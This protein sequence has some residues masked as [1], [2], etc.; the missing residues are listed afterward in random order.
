MPQA[1]PPSPIL[2][3]SAEQTLPA[4]FLAAAGT[5]AGVVFLGTDEREVR[6]SYRSLADRALQVAGALRRPADD[7]PWHVAI[8][9]RTSPAFY[10]A[11]FGILFAGA[12]PVVIPPPPR[13]APPSD[14]APRTAEMLRRS[15]T[16]RL[17][18]HRGLLPLMSSIAQSA[19]ISQCQAVE[20]IG[21]SKIR[22]RDAHPGVGAFL[23]F[24]SGSGGPPKAILLSHS[25]ILANVDAILGALGAEG[26]DRGTAV[27]WLPLHHD[28]GLVGC[29]LGAVRQ[30]A[31]LVL[32]PPELFVARPAFWLRAISRHRASV[33]AAPGFGY[34][35]AADRIKS[36]ELEGVDLSCWQHALNGAEQ[37]CPAVIERFIARFAPYGFQAESMR[38]V[39]GLAEAGLAVTFSPRRR[40]LSGHFSAQALGDG[41][42]EPA[43]AGF[44]IVSVGSPLY[45]CTV[46]I[47]DPQGGELA[48]GEVGDVLV[49]G[50]SVMTGYFGDTAGTSAAL[51]GGWLRT[52]DL[53]FLQHGELFIHGRSKDLVIL[54]GVK[55]APERIEAEAS[56]VAGCA[57]CAAVPVRLDGRETLGLVVERAAHW[58]TDRD[59]GLIQAVRQRVG[60][61]LSI[62]PELV[63]VVRRGSLP[64]TT[65][66]KLR[67]GEVSRLLASQVPVAIETK[68]RTHETA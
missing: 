9:L 36:G 43:E 37:V 16:E 19:K 55:Y 14:Y 6:E 48:E 47:V 61:V 53:G 34:A 63:A 67:R 20:E 27:S 40:Y 23:Q 7:I 66:G 31:D 41:G 1:R 42:V 18:T 65:S 5:D 54:N 29:L 12:R 57:A 25:Q 35:L 3:R 60:D 11:F 24:S 15:G 21:A 26:G 13:F 32:L 4:A 22:P 17:L 50:P 8:A 51:R 64:R 49:R 68:E 59:D 2:M 56:E 45:G 52:G 38:P 58:S 62:T 46:R 39:Y 30:Q 33:S 28:M 44:E 10:H